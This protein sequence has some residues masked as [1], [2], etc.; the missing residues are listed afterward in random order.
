MGRIYAPAEKKSWV[1][2]SFQRSSP[3]SGVKYVADDTV[4]PVT[5]FTASRAFWLCAVEGAGSLAGGA[6]G[7]C[8]ADC[9]LAFSGP[10]GAAPEFLS[11]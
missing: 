8:A 9:W 3:V 6:G 1:Q 4:K 5:G 2:Y 7:C 11:G 10:A